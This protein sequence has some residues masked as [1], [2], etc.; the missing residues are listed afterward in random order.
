MSEVAQS[1][2]ETLQTVFLP[3][4]AERPML[5]RYDPSLEPFLRVLVPVDADSVPNPEEAVMTSR[6]RRAGA[7]AR[8][9]GDG[10]WRRAD[11]GGTRNPRRD[12][13]RLDGG[14]QDQSGGHASFLV[15]ENVNMAG[16]S[17]IEG[18]KS[19]LIRTLNE[20]ESADSIRDLRIRRSNG[21]LIPMTDVAIVRVIATEM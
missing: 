21:V 15:S 19:Y 5:L 17:I 14:T 11:R 20:F 16:G 1:A 12:S 8:S 2:R 6:C 9:G 7:E 18:N 3:D 4:N 13:R 10:R